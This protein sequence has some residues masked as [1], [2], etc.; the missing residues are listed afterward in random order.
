MDIETLV[1]RAEITDVLVRYVRA[2]DRGDWAL[3]RACYHDDAYDDHGDYKGGPDG[4][5]V[6]VRAVAGRFM[7]TT[8]QLGQ[9]LI[10]VD[11]AHDRARAE[12]YCLGWYGRQ[13]SGS[14]KVWT[15]AQGL[16]YLDELTRRDGRWAISGRRVVMDW[17]HT[18]AVTH[19]PRLDAWLRGG[20]G[21]AD[22][23]KSFFTVDG[24]PVPSAS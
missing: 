17:E 11:P 19:P 9:L 21:P 6:H 12:T 4:L 3:L 14:G 20:Y 2:A 16:R 5:V 8:H 1:A 24:S 15:I 18:F 10:Q 22:P 23:S 13:P 7:F